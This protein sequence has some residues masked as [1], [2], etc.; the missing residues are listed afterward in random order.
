MAWIVLLCCVSKKGQAIIE[1]HVEVKSSCGYLV[2]LVCVGFTK[3]NATIRFRRPKSSTR[4]L[5]NPKEGG[6]IHDPKFVDQ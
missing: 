1:A 6:E 2:R 4:G 5:Q 3:N